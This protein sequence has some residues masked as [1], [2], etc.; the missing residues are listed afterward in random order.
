MRKEECNLNF[1][2]LMKWLRT[3]KKLSVEDE[4]ERNLAQVDKRM[5]K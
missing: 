1:R 5:V 2:K 3:K 4:V